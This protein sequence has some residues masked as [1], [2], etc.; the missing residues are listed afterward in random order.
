MINFKRFIQ[1]IIPWPNS[2]TGVG[3]LDWH[4]TY[5]PHQILPS[6]APVLLWIKYDFMR[7]ILSQFLT[8]FVCSLEECEVGCL[9]ELQYSSAIAPHKGALLA[10]LKWTN[11]IA[12]AVTA[13]SWISDQIW[14]NDYDLL[15][16]NYNV[17]K[18]VCCKLLPCTGLC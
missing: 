13:H 16:T 5:Q 11:L 4:S 14:K 6:L 8:G 1:S 17:F 12:S 15:K 10:L 3:K 18:T 9:C 7:Y 2:H